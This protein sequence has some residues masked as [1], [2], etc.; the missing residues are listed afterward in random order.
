MSRRNARYF[1]HGLFPQ[2]VVFE[3]V[4]R[5]GSATRA[6]EEL[7]LAQPTVST[8]LAKLSRALDLTLHEPDGRGLRLTAA[9]RALAAACGELIDLV[10]RT[11]RTLCPYRKGCNAAVLSLA[12]QQDTHGHETRNNE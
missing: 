11:E 10:E 3:A 9:G 7:H 8:Q 2:L 6:A 1:R 5:L 12:I 4:A